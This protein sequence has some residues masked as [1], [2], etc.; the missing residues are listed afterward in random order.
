MP[1]N[2]AS[3]VTLLDGLLALGFISQMPLDPAS[4]KA[5]SPLSMTAMPCRRVPRLVITPTTLTTLEGVM[6]STVLLRT[7]TYKLVKPSMT[8]AVALVNLEAFVPTSV[9]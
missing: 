4:L 1:L 3:L 7:V 2:P 9:G 8:I 6:H 5:S